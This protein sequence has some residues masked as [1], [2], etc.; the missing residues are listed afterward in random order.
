[1][2]LMVYLNGKELLVVLLVIVEKVLPLMDLV[3][4]ISLDILLVQVREVMI[5]S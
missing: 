3:M 5:F 1:M 4:F 2:I